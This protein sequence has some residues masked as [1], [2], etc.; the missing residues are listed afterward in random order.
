MSNSTKKQASN[1]SGDGVLRSAHN[2]ADATI[3]VSGF[4]SSKV[5][6]KIVR[7]VISATIDDYSFYDDAELLYTLRITYNN[8][9]HDEIDQVERTV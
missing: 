1:L 9:S 7:S 3:A 2:E 4:V 5:G 6:H 8:S